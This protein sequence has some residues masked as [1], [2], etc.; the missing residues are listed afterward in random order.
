MPWIELAIQTDDTHAQVLSDA[1]IELG[2]LSTDIHDA[3]AGT[4]CEQPL[5]DEPGEEPGRFWLASELTALLTMTQTYLR[6][7][8]LRQKRLGFQLPSAIA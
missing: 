3:A 8:T 7:C 4:E 2:A 5:F 1:L 6:F